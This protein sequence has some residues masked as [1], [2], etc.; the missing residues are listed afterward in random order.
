MDYLI[1]KKK[2]YQQGDFKSHNKIRSTFKKKT[3]W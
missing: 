3:V 1:K 2:K